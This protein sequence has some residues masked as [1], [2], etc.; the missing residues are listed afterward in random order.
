MRRW[1]GW[2]STETHYPLPE[3][4]AR[5]LLRVVGPGAPFEPASQEACLNSV[6][7]SRLPDHPLVSQNAE[8]RLAHACGQSLPDWVSLRWGKF[9][10]FPDG[11]AMPRDETQ[12]RQ[13]L[14]YAKSNRVAVIPYG[15]GTSVVGHINP[16]PD[17][18]PTLTLDLSFLNQLLDLDET[19]RLA[20]FQPGICGPDLEAALNAHGY[21]LGHFPQSFELSTLGGWVAARSS[22]QQSYYYGR[23]E[24]LFAGGTLETP[25]GCL[26]LPTTPASAA[27]PD[28]RQVVLGSEGRLGVLTRAVVRIRSLP[29]TEQFYGVFFPDWESGI[30]AARALAQ[31]KVALSMIRLS[32]PQETETTLELS[33]KERLVTLA[34]RGLPVLGYGRERALLVFGVTGPARTARQAYRQA[35]EICRSRHG[36]P[37]IAMIG[38]LWRKSRFLTP[39][40][41]NTL[42]DLGYGL[43]TLETALPWSRFL[44]AAQEIPGALRQ[45]AQIQDRR[46]LVFAHLSHVY[47]DGASLYVTYL[48]PLL[49]GPDETLAFW[50]GL[51]TAAS[52]TILEHGGTISHQHGVGLD[53]AGYL[54]AEKGDLGMRLLRS[55]AEAV[56]PQG[57]MNPGKL[58]A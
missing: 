55:L 31:E 58:F 1:N 24:D 46:I 20:A 49:P 21:S 14:D 42:W 52:H 29:E 48:F 51:K 37:P 26:E 45:A 9:P 11:V 44:H 54:P 25:S 2:G 27:G 15:G 5:Y 19:S 8:D 10:A 39:Y 43:D 40:L 53:H 28:L 16:L 41:R 57:L 30:E 3:P 17:G 32:T 33:G 7:P 34:N 12:V 35:V 18:L 23:I 56:D 6:P 36:T 38:R 50:Q 4:A 13:I 47:K 22:G